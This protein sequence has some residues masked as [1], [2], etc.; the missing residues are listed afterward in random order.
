MMNHPNSAPLMIPH[1]L[2]V[3]TLQKQHK[4]PSMASALI[5]F[6][7]TGEVLK[8]EAT[9]QF[10][11]GFANQNNVRISAEKILIFASTIIHTL[12]N[13]HFMEKKKGTWWRS[14]ATGLS[15]FW[16]LQ[17][18]LFGVATP[19]IK[20]ATLYTV[21]LWRNANSKWLPVS[22]TKIVHYCYDR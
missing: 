3:K 2:I 13:Y 4:N 22:E 11:Y 10:L 8:P 21:R 12:L 19:Y 17:N 20:R 9:F 15:Y 6:F 5:F 16:P 1:T 18:T 7:S 14:Q